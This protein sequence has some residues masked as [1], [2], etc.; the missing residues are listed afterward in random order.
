MKHRATEHP[1]N[2]TFTYISGANQ[3]GECFFGIYSHVFIV[4]ALLLLYSVFQMLLW[5][6][7][8]WKGKPAFLILVVR[9]ICYKNMFI[10]F[11]DTI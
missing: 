7:P 1:R 6:I 11:P 5:Y 10:A 9:K 8:A 3:V 4:Y 2:Q